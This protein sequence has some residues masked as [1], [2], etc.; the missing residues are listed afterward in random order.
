MGGR[1]VL[2]HNETYFTD[3][4]PVSDQV[5]VSHRL[6]TQRRRARHRAAGVCIECGRPRDSRYGTC[7]DCRVGNLIR[8]ERSQYLAI[9]LRVAQEPALP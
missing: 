3:Y 5:R 8:V 4:H 9:R 2:T 6:R 7:A 1:R